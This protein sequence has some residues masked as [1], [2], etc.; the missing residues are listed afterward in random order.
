[1]STRDATALKEN[2]Q[3]RL[4]GSLSTG[5]FSWSMTL[6]VSVY[7]WVPHFGSL[8]T[9]WVRILFSVHSLTV[10]TRM[11]TQPWYFFL[12]SHRHSHLCC[13][14]CPVWK[15]TPLNHVYHSIAFSN[16]PLLDDSTHLQ[17]VH[18]VFPALFE[19]LIS[20]KII[21]NKQKFTC[22]CQEAQLSLIYL[23]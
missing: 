16:E 18:F 23:Q 12:N 4:F 3:P 14:A 13:P 6:A 21:E 10:T 11:L 5:W 17:C 19:L 20:V 2:T 7:W 15:Q 8:K 1:M 9:N 22:D